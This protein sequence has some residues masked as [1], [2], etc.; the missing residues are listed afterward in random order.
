MSQNPKDVTPQH[1]PTTPPKF[2]TPAPPT[3]K[4]SG[5]QYH[6]MPPDKP[7]KE[8]LLVTLGDGHEMVKRAA[9]GSVMVGARA[10]EEIIRRGGTLIG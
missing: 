2:A 10:A 6:V 9:D 5:T 3:P 4:P 7:S 8:D 1:K